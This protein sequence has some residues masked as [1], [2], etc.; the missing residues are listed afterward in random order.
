MN[1]LEFIIDRYSL[2][3]N[4]NPIKISQ[5][6]WHDMGHLF[7]DLG[8]KKGVEVGVYKAR[9]TTCLAKRMPNCQI[10]GIDAWTVYKGYK[11]YENNDLESMAQKEAERRT[12][13]FTNV[14]L[15][16]DWSMDAVK[17]F[18]DES[19]DFVFIDANHDF[20]C[21][22]AD[23]AAWS[24]KVRRGGIVCGHDYFKNK[25]HNFGV[26]EAVNGWCDAYDIKPLFIWTDNCPNWMYVK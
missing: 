22:V 24:K 4:D 21:V 17:Q 8:F 13:G 14:K 15:I 11:D 6:R 3:P 10:I 25:R 7:N 16:K 12:K 23:I 26:V 5:S 18:E 9:F 19:I 20:E 1:T 2:N